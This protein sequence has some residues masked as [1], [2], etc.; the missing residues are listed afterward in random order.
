MTSASQAL[1]RAAEG[2]VP[3]RSNVSGFK[4]LQFWVGKPL[5]F[6]LDQEGWTTGQLMDFGLADE[7]VQR[8]FLLILA[9]ALA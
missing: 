3:T 1:R 4:T 7:G 8:N 2:Q 6:W 5:E 9:E